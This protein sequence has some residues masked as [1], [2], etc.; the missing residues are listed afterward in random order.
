MLVRIDWRTVTE[1]HVAPGGMLRLDP[2]AAARLWPHH[3]DA[4][5]FA[6][7]VGI[8]HA[9]GLFR[10]LAGL[11]AAPSGRTGAPAR[12]F[13]DPYGDGEPVDTPHGR[14]RQLGE[15][16]QSTVY[17]HADDG[18]IWISDPDHEV[19]YERVHGDLSSFSYLVYKTA[20]ERPGPEESPT[21]YDWADIDE[22]I[23][24]GMDRWDPLPFGGTTH[25]WE[26]F[27]DSYP[28]L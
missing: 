11:A 12:A 19:E 4:A 16:Y 10:L 7:E 25:F 6:A 1:E 24:E 23:R 18:T 13:T 14:L 15:V 20:V 5:R 8:P 26:M 2:A 22:I 17:V 21:P 27:L 9:D 3:P 28:M